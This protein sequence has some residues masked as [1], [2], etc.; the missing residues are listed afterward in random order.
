MVCNAL[1]IRFGHEGPDSLEGN[2]TLY[3]VTEIVVAVDEMLHDFVRI[4]QVDGEIRFSGLFQ[5]PTVES[6]PT[7]K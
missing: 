7:N 6:T 3:F 2:G 5:S 1:L 4:P